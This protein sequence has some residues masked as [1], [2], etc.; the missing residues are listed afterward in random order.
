MTAV[1]KSMEELH[2]VWL[3]LTGK[4]QLQCDHC[5][6]ESGP[7]STH[8]AM[9]IHDWIRVIDEA[10]E[11][12]VRMVQFIGGEPTLH[13]NLPYLIDQAVG[14]RMAVEIF[15]NLFC[16]SQR[17]WEVFSLPGVR[18]AT[19]YYADCAAQHEGITRRRGSYESTKTNIIEA[20]RRSI[21]LRVGVIDVQDGQRVEQACAELK[22][23]GVLRLLRITFD[24]SAE[25]YGTRSRIPPS[26]AGA[27]RGARWPLRL[28]VRCGRAYLPA[29][30]PSAT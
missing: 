13:P 15:S 7:R 11:L 4:C 25:E 28:T 1:L 12:G 21:P 10:R 18:L 14:R 22:A 2:F 17:L 30:C 16:V 29:G 9:R 3:E 24:K 19:S 5:Y 20:V 23:L 8:G 6:S 27:A 26:S